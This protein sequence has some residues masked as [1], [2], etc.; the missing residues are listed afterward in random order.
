MSVGSCFAYVA[1]SLRALVGA[2]FAFL[3]EFAV[4]RKAFQLNPAEQ[5]AYALSQA[6]Q[7]FAA[8]LFCKLDEAAAI[9]E[10]NPAAVNRLAD[11]PRP[12][13]ILRRVPP[14]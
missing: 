14:I 8:E 10:T 12:H 11:D 1:I 3:M 5:S 4:G 13:A 7:R 6:E 2:L 9:S